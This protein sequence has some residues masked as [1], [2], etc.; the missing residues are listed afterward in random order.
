MDNPVIP[1][2]IAV[3]LYCW[4]AFGFFSKGAYGTGFA[5][6]CYALSNCGFIYATLREIK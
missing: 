1:L 6:A 5:W 4:V 3:V 2:S